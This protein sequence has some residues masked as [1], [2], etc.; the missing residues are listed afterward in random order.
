VPHFGYADLQISISKNFSEIAEQLFDISQIET[1]TT[2][3]FDKTHLYPVA[4][5]T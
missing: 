3:N 5:E 2:L 4:M 1:E